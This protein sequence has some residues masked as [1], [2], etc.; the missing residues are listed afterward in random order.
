MHLFQE[1]ASPWIGGTASHV[2]SDPFSDACFDT[3]QKWIDT[4]LK[5]HSYCS[6]PRNSARLE[7]SR[8]KRLVNVGTS[9]KFDDI[10]LEETQATEVP[11]FA[12]SHCWGTSLHLTTTKSTIEERKR[13]IPWHSIP[14]TFQDAIKVTRRLGHQFLWIDSLCIIQDDAQDW[15]E[16]SAKM[17][18]IYQHAFIVL[19]ATRAPNGDVGCLGNRTTSYRIEGTDMHGTP[20]QV[21]AREI[22]THVAHFWGVPS[23]IFADADDGARSKWADSTSMMSK[24]Y[25]LLTRS[26]CYQE[27]LLATR[28]LHFEETEMVWEC[29]TCLNCECGAIHDY[30]NKPSLI[31]RQIAAGFTKAIEPSEE[32]EKKWRNLVAGLYHSDISS[33]NFDEV[34]KLSETIPSLQFSHVVKEAGNAALLVQQ[35]RRIQEDPQA[36][37]FRKWRNIVA[38]YTT[39]QLTYDLDTLPALS[40]LASKWQNS[41][42]GKY[43]AGTWEHDFLAG[44]LW[45]AY[46]EE[47]PIKD[48]IAPSWS[49]ASARRAVE[50]VM[51]GDE[52]KWH[53]QIFEKDIS[54]KGTSIFGQVCHGYITLRGGLIEGKLQSC[55]QGT[56]YSDGAIVVESMADRGH[57]I[58]LDRYDRGAALVGKTVYCLRLC[59]DVM[60]SKGFGGYFERGLVLSRVMA[61][62][63]TYKRIGFMTMEQPVDVWQDVVTERVITIV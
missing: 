48:Y 37:L 42:T 59:T 36:R 52:F 50:W 17:G 60:T 57:Y 33:L 23:S 29:L 16:E 56:A 11:Y 15:E 3:T 58:Y 32:D 13:V 8:P 31:P 34:Q 49:W 61:G 18:S 41:Q 9:I 53:I 40:G 44:M 55:D 51:A 24:H 1:T 54:L 62:R 25:P 30:R 43:L 38:D 47:K 26:W 21:Y 45:R 4:C 28:V 22:N 2:P 46:G 63:E 35:F 27:S 7:A 5:E 10:C 6:G 19:A 39:R 14:K 12:L 20:F